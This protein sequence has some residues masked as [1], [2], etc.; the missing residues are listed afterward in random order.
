MPSGTYL[1]IPSTYPAISCP[2]VIG[3]LIG[4]MFLRSPLIICKSLLHNPVAPTF[5][6]TCS[7]FR[8]F[9]I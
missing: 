1:P 7:P 2:N 4:I 9:G 3:R 6:N 5:T 8:F